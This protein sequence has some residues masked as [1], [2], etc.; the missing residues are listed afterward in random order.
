[1]R[2]GLPLPDRAISGKRHNAVWAQQKMID[3][4]KLLAELHLAHVERDPP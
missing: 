2:N 1:M 4:T 3:V